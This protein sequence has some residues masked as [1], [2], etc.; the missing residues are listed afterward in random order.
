MSRPRAAKLA[1]KVDFSRWKTVVDIGGSE[2]EVCIQL[3]LKY[4]HLSLATLDLPLVSPLAKKAVEKVGLS[5]R[6]RVGDVD[7][8]KE[9]LPL[10]DVI[11]MSHIL[12]DWDLPT[13]KMLIAK[14]LRSLN[15][16]GAFIVLEELI[17][18]ERR[19]NVQGLLM[20]LN[21]LIE[22]GPAFDFTGADLASWC[23][24]AGFS[25]VEIVSLVGPTSAGIAYK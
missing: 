25:R 2:G 4:P 10:A 11:I 21:M 19:T 14:V 6:I 1:E 18:D 17:D 16:G 23:R 9:E 13:K 24:V 5:G 20:S 7:F 8:F 3:A 12:H 15:P 22:V